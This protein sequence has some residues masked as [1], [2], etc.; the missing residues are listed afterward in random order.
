MKPL[1][2]VAA[3]LTLLW[4]PVLLAQ[5]TETE[6]PAPTPSPTPPREL[7]DPVVFHFA[8]YA[9]ATFIS[10]RGRDSEGAM[11]FAPIFHVQAGDRFFVETEF[12]LEATDSGERKTAIEYANL[13]WLINDNLA[14]VVGKFLSPAGNFFQN[15]HPSWI[16]KAASAPAGFG[17]GGAAPLS[18]VGLQLRGGKAF[19]GGQQ[20]NYSL[21]YANG[22]RLRLEGMGAPADEGEVEEFEFDLDAEG[23]PDNPDGKRVTGGRVGWMPMSRLELG[24]SLVR[25]NVVLDAAGMEVGMAEPSRDYRVSGID[26]AWYPRPGLELRAEWI[27]QELGAA[28]M[29]LVPQRAVWRAWYTQGAYRFG[30]DKWEAVARYGDSVS[31][32]S[33]A[34]VQQTAIGLNYLI[35]PYSQVKL[36]WEFND[37]PDEVANADRLLLQIAYGF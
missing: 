21:Y 11:T 24:A 14:L 25:G 13:N 12:E 22:P 4:N 18:D 10:A 32:H 33:E 28:A 1:V 35:R 2:L 5:A 30:N 3:I 27:R 31:P 7:D 20:V 9:D 8:G 36:N 23:S 37:S 19:A 34:T 16:N 15:L 29:S 26:A 6:V 17:H